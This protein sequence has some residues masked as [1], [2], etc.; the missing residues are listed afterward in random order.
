MRINKYLSRAGICSRRD[1]K[2]LLINEEVAI[3]GNITTSPSDK[4]CEGDVVTYK[5]DVINISPREVWVYYKPVGCLTTKK[6]PQ[7]RATIY[8][9][10][11]KHLKSFL[12]IGRLDYNSEGL[13]LLT[14]DGE[15]KR[16]LELPSNKIE[17]KYKVRIFGKFNPKHKKTIEAGVKISGIKYQVK[18]LEIIKIGVNS[19]LE[20]SLE[21]GKNREIRIILDHF[22]YQV[23]R[24]IR[25]TYGKYKI[26]SLSPNNVIKADI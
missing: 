3:N 18:S 6:D 21:E 13:L 14:N 19:W 26:N 22:G 16:F 4:V 23:N 2:L 7:N 11:P 17:R 15:Y 8:D 25:I 1:A 24:L 10:L 9:Y 12:T 20:M 5:N